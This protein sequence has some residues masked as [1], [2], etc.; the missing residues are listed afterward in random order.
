MTTADA[1]LAAILAAPEDDTPRLIFADWLEE[2]GDPARA[3]F[4]RLQIEYDKHC[5]PHERAPL[6]EPMRQRIRELLVLPGIE[7]INCNGYC[8]SE[9]LHKLRI[10]KSFWRTQSFRRGFVECVTMEGDQWVEHAD[11]LRA[12]HP[13][14]DVILTEGP[15]IITSDGGWRLNK[16]RSAWTPHKDTRTIEQR[17]FAAEWP[18][19]RFDWSAVLRQVNEVG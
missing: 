8:W 10:E 17:L 15:T 2:D 19:I 6:W 16:R 5:D 18:T 11:V 14:R 4:I 12:L 1:F 3:E 13:I 7:G 9:P